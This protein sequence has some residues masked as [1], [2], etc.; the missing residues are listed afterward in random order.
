MS[1]KR[2]H[3]TYLTL[4]PSHQPQ[5]PNA[6][7]RLAASGRLPILGTLHKRAQKVRGSQR[8]RGDVNPETA[9]SDTPVRTTY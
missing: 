2:P 4:D 5:Q 6:G 1:F 3:S 8:T 9:D 7:S